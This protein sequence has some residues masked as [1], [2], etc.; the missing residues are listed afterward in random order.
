MRG[1]V[2]CDAGSGASFDAIQTEINN[3]LS[4]LARDGRYGALVV[5]E[6]V[7]RRLVEGDPFRAAQTLHDYSVDVERG[8]YQ[9]R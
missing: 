2:H 9:Q 1:D 4:K 6:G 7:C 5:I 8:R 3:C